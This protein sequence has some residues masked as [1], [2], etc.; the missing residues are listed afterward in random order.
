MYARPVRRGV[1]L[2]AACV[3]VSGFVTQ[4]SGRQVRCISLAMRRDDMNDLRIDVTKLSPKEQERLAFIQKLTNE[5]DEFA[6]AAGFAVDKE[7][8]EKE[9][10]DTKWSGYVSCL[11]IKL[12]HVFIKVTAA[13]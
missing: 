11:F 1:L 4:F 10:V 3:C 7:V 2:L 12:S 6:K 5:A 9:V 13:T 8:E